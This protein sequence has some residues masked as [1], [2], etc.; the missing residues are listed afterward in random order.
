[1]EGDTRLDCGEAD[2]NKLRIVY[3]LMN[4]KDF[5]IIERVGRIYYYFPIIYNVLLI[6]IKW[7]FP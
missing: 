1:M 6:S 7:N 4:L 3:G 5:Y 2:V